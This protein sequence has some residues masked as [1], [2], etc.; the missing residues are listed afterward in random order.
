MS[1]IIQQQ[2]YSSGDPEKNTFNSVVVAEDISGSW[3][4]SGHDN[5]QWSKYM[6][7][8]ALMKF[9]LK[10]QS[11]GKKTSWTHKKAGNGKRDATKILSTNVWKLEGNGWVVTNHRAE[12][13]I[14]KEQDETDLTSQTVEGLHEKQ[15]HCQI[16][17]TREYAS[18]ILMPN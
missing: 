15:L 4:V 18:L 6:F 8:S 3:R 16:H 11:K 14:K 12:S 9:H 7:I 2:S 13:W 1:I 5:I 17:S 10:W